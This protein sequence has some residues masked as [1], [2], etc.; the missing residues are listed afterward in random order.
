[1]D[2]PQALPKDWWD[3]IERL[4]NLLTEGLSARIIAMTAT[5]PSL[6]RNLETVSLLETGL[7]HQQSECIYCESKDPYE[8]SL[9][10]SPR[11]TYFD[12]AQRVRYT[13]DS[14]A[15]S[16]RIGAT[17]SHIGYKTAAKRVLETV[18]E[19]EST[20]AICNTISSSRELTETVCNQPK[21]VHLGSVIEDILMNQDVDAAHPQTAID[22]IVKRVLEQVTES[23]AQTTD[24]M[25]TLV[26]TLNSRYRPF[27]REILIELADRLSTSSIPFVLISTQAIEAGVDLSFRT[28]FRDIAPLDSIVQAAGRCN[29][30]YEW[31]EDG[32]DVIVWMLADPDEPSP[33]NPSKQPPAYYVYEKGATD[34]GIPGHLE[35]ISTVLTNI[36]DQGDIPAVALSRDAVS[37]YFKAL[38]E[39]SLWSGDLR[40]AINNCK[41]RWLGQQ[42]LIGGMETVDVLVALTT[43]DR[44]ELETLSELIQVGDPS[45]Y[46]RLQQ[47][48]G[49]R[50]S[51]PKS[52]VED[53][54]QLSRLDKKERD[55]DGVSVLEFRGQKGL[56]Y[57]LTDGG[58]VPT[59][60]PIGDR[61]TL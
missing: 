24:P 17:E 54:P 61:F 2:E 32:G 55:S 37:E 33:D 23:D 57:D 3:G 14:T 42:S 19:G 27:D 41:G 48:A 30:S 6:V 13:I 18:R 16:K 8:V 45:G 39:K 28:V 1:L 11:E 58:L 38:D 12:T 43:T 22:T 31:G 40:E 21:T 4:L 53:T 26:L 56:T 15:Q 25:Q 51:V 49:I 44:K 60:D 52:L 50:V 34:A 29:R 20:L 46:D 10:A 35:L 47:A 59:T 5:Q 9:P 36:P 7:D